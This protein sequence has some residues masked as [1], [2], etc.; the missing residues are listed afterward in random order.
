MRNAAVHPARTALPATASPGA[1]PPRGAPAFD[2]VTGHAVAAALPA[3]SE[4]VVSRVCGACGACGVGGVGAWAT[5]VL[6]AGPGA[7]AGSGDGGTAG[8]R[9]GSSEA[10]AC[11]IPPSNGGAVEATQV[12]KYPPGK[13]GQGT[14]LG[15]SAEKL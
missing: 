4:D 7:V 11:M 1:S 5:R 12:M 15:G 14:G 6:A 13:A 9:A 10:W 3:L 8:K 2:A